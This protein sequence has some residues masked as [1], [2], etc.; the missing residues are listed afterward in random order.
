[1]RQVSAAFLDALRGAHTA[2]TRATVVTTWQTGTT[3]A[4]TRV[5][6]DSGDVRLAA[7]AAIRG[8]LDLTVLGTWPGPAE[9]AGWLLAPYGNEIY[10]ERGVDF[11]NGTV[12]WVGQGYY[13]IDSA[14]QATVLRTGHEQAAVRLAGSD[15]MAGIID[16]RLL[17]PQQFPATATYGQVVAQL[18][19]EVYPSAVVQFDDGLGSVQL[20]RQVVCEQ[21][22]YA[23]LRDLVDARG[24]VFHFNHLG[25]PVVRTPPAAT[26]PV[27]T[28]DTGEGG[29]LIALARQ[30]SREGVRNGVVA[31]GQAADTTAPARGVA[32]DDN[33]AS[34]TRWG[35]RFGKVPRF[36]S[37]PL[38]LTDDQARTAAAAILART[39]GLPYSVNLTAVPNV[40]LEPLDPVRV[41][42]PLGDEV[43][44]IR[45]L[46][47]PLSPAQPM[48]ATTRQVTTDGGDI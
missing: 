32:V 9:R 26:S 24:K 10:V 21:D 46:V 25:V 15:R 13:R 2:V 6:V 22:R 7:D 42:T 29:V 4:G 20:G 44:V 8:T 28:V 5:D 39:L 33:P 40:A 31:T 41:V 35:G 12:E 18:V 34:P 36:Y 19:G 11:G 45:E 1:M 16:A 47:V 37:S 3:P 27:W 48:T 17:A 43:H 30:I 38:I 14:E 23:F